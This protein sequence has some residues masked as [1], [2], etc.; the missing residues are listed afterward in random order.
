MKGTTAAL[1]FGMLIISIGLAWILTGGISPAADVSP[2]TGPTLVPTPVPVTT[3]REPVVTISPVASLPAVPS[4]TTGAPEITQTLVI[5]E[6]TQP[7]RTFSANQVRDHF[8][9]IAYASTNRLER[10][11]YSESHPRVTVSL[12]SGVDSDKAVIA[13][14]AQEFNAVSRDVKISEMPKEGDSGDVVIKFLPATGLNV[15]ALND[16]PGAGPF[17]ESLTRGELKYKGVVAARIMRGTI[18]VNGDLERNAENH[19]L[20]RSLMYELGVTGETTVYPESLFYSGDNTNTKLSAVDQ[21][22]IA[23]LYEPGLANGMTLDDL[24]KVIYIP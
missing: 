14:T 5:T 15:I 16:I 7:E 18:Y 20:A 3:V 22:A 12:V 13:D 4:I 9:D 17:N 10:L 19:I 8:L 23:L 24:K 21:K 1:I 6:T 11:N 2:P